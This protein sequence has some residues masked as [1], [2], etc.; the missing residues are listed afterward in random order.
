MALEENPGRPIGDREMHLN[1][2]MNGIPLTRVQLQMSDYMRAPVLTRQCFCRKSAAILLVKKKESKFVG[3]WVHSCGQKNPCGFFQPE[4][5]PPVEDCWCGA[6]RP[7]KMCVSQKDSTK[8]WHFITCGMNQCKYF[9]WF[10]IQ[11]RPQA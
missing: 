10:P 4:S 1:P 11:M 7:G 3:Q 6:G 9:R 8:G 5:Q 2:N